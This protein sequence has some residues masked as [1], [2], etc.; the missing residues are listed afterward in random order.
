MDSKPSSQLYPVP[1][2]LEG[3]CVL[4]QMMRLRQS[5]WRKIS[6]SA[7]KEV[8]NEAAAYFKEAEKGSQGQTAV[9]SLIGDKGDLMFIHFR[10]SVEQLKE[11][12]LQIGG[13]ALADYLTPAY[14]F[15]SVIELGLYES[16]V[17]LFRSLAEK[18][19][20][21]HSEVWK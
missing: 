20:E 8:A 18:G 21:P 6:D 17:K 10:E 16:S 4:H 2:S 3:H 19:I 14:S 15:L 1:L 12:E 5:A 7:R 9:F 13:L 11:A